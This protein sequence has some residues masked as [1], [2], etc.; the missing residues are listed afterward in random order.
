MSLKP[1]VEKAGTFN[2]Q[3]SFIVH[4]MKHNS[5][6]EK[7][8]L[9]MFITPALDG[10]VIKK[11]VNDFFVKSLIATGAMPSTPNP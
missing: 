11:F 8:V 10:D 7:T 3:I 2:Y 4:Y 6:Y 1:Y 5:F 9:R